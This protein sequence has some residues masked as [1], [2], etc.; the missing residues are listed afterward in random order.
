[1]TENELGEA[2]QLSVAAGPVLNMLE[3]LR[4]TAYYKMLS[5]FRLGK[6]DHLAKVAE[7]NAYTTIME[8]I[9]Y[10]LKRLNAHYEKEQR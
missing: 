2:K 6:S 3:G 5:D 10:K 1:M 4:K 9:E 7:C 8:E